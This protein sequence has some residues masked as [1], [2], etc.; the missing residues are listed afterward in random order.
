[1]NG[2]FSLAFC[3]MRLRGILVT[4]LGGA[5]DLTTFSYIFSLGEWVELWYF[6]SFTTLPV[7]VIHRSASGSRNYLQETRVLN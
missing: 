6:Q 7:P 2:P 3:L 1:M 5:V 4:A